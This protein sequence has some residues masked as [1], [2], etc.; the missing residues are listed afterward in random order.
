MFSGAAMRTG[1]VWGRP[2]GAGLIESAARRAQVRCRRTA[3]SGHRPMN[4][5]WTTHRSGDIKENRAL[6]VDRREIFRSE[7]FSAL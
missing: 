6:E 3:Q 5:I 4:N 7:L 1:K 2:C